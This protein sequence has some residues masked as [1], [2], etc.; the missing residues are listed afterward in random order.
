HRRFKLHQN[1]VSISVAV[2]LMAIC[3]WF[4]TAFSSVH[5][6]NLGAGNNLKVSGLRDQWLRGDVVVMIRHAERC[7]RST[8]PCMA[9]A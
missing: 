3:A 8:N 2:T 6:V 1:I 5:V 7:D 9:S 4:F